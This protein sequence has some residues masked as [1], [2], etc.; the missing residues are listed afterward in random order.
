MQSLDARG[1]HDLADFEPFRDGNGRGVVAQHVDVPRGN[2]QGFWIDDPDT[3]PAIEVGEG[4]RWNLDGGRGVELHASDH[5]RA[6]PHRCGRI[7]QA[8]L[9][10]ERPGD[11]VGLWR[12]L[13]DPS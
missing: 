12:Y 11:R 4:T 5:G 1:H 9:D 2:S 7:G 10:L 6:E 8:D 13:P 3:G